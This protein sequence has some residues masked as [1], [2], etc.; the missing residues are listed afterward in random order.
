MYF[1]LINPQPDIRVEE[2]RLQTTKTKWSS[3]SMVSHKVIH[4]PKH[5]GCILRCRLQSNQDQLRTSVK[6]NKAINRWRGT[7]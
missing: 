2:S 1:A 5:T 4:K 3:Y 6:S 7:E